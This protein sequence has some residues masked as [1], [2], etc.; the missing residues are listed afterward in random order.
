MLGVRGLGSKF[1]FLFFFVTSARDVAQ[2]R[3]GLDLAGTANVHQGAQEICSSNE[4]MTWRCHSSCA[5]AQSSRA[6]FEPFLMGPVQ[7]S[8][9]LFKPREKM[10]T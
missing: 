4:L 7:I 5:P 10:L 3:S 6:H 1:F 2:R 8:W 9:V